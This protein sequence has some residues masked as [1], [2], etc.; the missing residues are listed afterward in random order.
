MTCTQW[1]RSS[2]PIHVFPID[3]TREH[4]LDSEFCPCLPAVLR[5][6]DGVANIVRHN[7]YD[8][9]EIGEVCRK[10]M[11]VMELALAHHHHR[12]TE[13]ERDAYD[14]AHDVLN[15]RYPREL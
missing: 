11:E 1:G 13:D 10:A 12:W 5:G 3:D 4:V 14:H 9:R 8:G 7:S 6:E 2:D 15:V